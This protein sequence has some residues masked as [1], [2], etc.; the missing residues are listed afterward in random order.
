MAKRK[1]AYRGTPEHHYLRAKSHT[2]AVRKMALSVRDA[3]AHG[4]CNAAMQEL[5]TLNRTVG[6]A[7]AQNAEAGRKMS[8]IP[9]S[10]AINLETKFYQKCVVRRTR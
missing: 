5:G 1:R 8:V 7:Q 2:K 10:V 4:D 9:W 3:L 6:K